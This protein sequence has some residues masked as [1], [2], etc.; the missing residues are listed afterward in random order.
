[1]SFL[2]L[3]NR[4]EMRKSSSRRLLMLITLFRKWSLPT[5]ACSLITVREHTIFHAQNVT[6]KSLTCHV[7]HAF[8]NIIYPI[9]ASWWLILVQQILLP[10]VTNET[11]IPRRIKELE[12]FNRVKYVISKLF[13]H[14]AIHLFYQ[15]LGGVEEK[16]LECHSAL[17]TFPDCR[18][19]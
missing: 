9:T 1:M 6:H 4:T 2:N 3:A 11:K 19:H 18:L 12:I 15:A 8:R 13:F 5:E 7:K 17:S 10:R 14:P 16:S